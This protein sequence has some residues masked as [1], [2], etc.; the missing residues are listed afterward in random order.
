MQIWPQVRRFVREDETH[1]LQLVRH[2][3]RQFFENEYVSRGSDAS[4]TVAHVLAV[5]AVPPALYTLYLIPA[6]DAIFWHFPEKYGAYCLIDQCRFVTFSMVVVGFIALLEWDALFL[7]Y[8]D[9]AILGPLPLQAATIFGAKIAALVLF[10][11]LFVVAVGAVPTVLYPVVETMGMRGAPVSGPVVGSVAYSRMLAWG[12]PVSS[13]HF[14]RMMASHAVAVFSAGA[15]G[16]LFFAAIQGVLINVLSARVFKKVSLA[17]QIIGMVALLLLLFLLPIYSLLIPRWQQAPFPSL[18][19]FPPLWF[20]G[21]YQ[22]LLGSGDALFRSSA[23][24]GAAALGLVT[25]TCIAAYTLNYKRHMQRAL[26]SAEAEPAGPSRVADGA[27]W[28]LN[29]LV[30]RKP[31]ERATFFFVLNTV[32]RS[33]KHRLYLATYTGVG[34]AL[35]AFGIME[36]LVNTARRDMTPILF[37]PND[38]LL[39]IPLILSFFL[40]SGM[41]VAFS[42]PAELR[43]NWAFQI[44]EDKDWLDCCAGAR[45]AMTAAAVLL[46]FALLPFYAVLWGWPAALQQLT[47]G[48]M[49]SLILIELL[50][51]NFRK[52]PF[53]CSYQAGKANIT[54]LGVVYWFAFTTYAYTMA[55]LERWLLQNGARWIAFFALTLVVLEALVIRRKTT[56]IERPGIVFE[57]EPNPELQTLGLGA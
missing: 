19:K 53:T 6:Y 20:L 21:V 17:I 23:R 15:F 32:L 24:I 4:L 26:E 44:A 34:F 52:I 31:Q 14:G 36:V 28:L 48:L 40:L 42:M 51:V 37:E 13:W 8:R 41:R 11:L 43:A 56:V 45:K 22:T 9:H 54:I 1:F 35:A 57:D 39:A 47:F 25:L 16:F 27:R 55:A 3:F 33:S 38:A 46:L 5:L 29:R 50:L 12:T 7:D 49:L 30:L 2:F 10:L 18:H